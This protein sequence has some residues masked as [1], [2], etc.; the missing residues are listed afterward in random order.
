[1]SDSDRLKDVIQARKKEME[2]NEARIQKLVEDSRKRRE[3]KD[4]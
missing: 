2:D 1:M 3:E 4:D